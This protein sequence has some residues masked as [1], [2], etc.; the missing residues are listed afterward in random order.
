[1][2]DAIRKSLAPAVVV[3]MTGVVALDPSSPVRAPVPSAPVDGYK[4]G[5]AYAPTLAPALAEGWLAAADAIEAGKSVGEAQEA[6]QSAFKAAR[7]RA[8]SARVVPEFARVLPE[9][10]EPEDAAARARVARLWRD[11]ARGLRGGE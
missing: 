9:G 11:F 10:A 8:F 2:R 4:L 3:L 6:L 5:R 7:V 1:M